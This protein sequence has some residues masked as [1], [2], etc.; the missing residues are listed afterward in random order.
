MALED[1]IADP[2][3]TAIPV[4]GNIET[5]GPDSNQVFDLATLCANLNRQRSYSIANVLID[6]GVPVVFLR[7]WR[8]WC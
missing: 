5:A 1:M 4:A 6:H 8:A 3:C 7:K 2:G